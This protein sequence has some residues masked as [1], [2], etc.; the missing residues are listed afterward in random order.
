LNDRKQPNIS[1]Y[2]AAYDRSTAGAFALSKSNV[3]AVQSII[4]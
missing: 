4:P 1:E 2:G 3:E